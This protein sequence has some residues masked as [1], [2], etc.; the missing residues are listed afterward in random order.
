MQTPGSLYSTAPC[1][2]NSSPIRV[3]PAPGPPQMRAVRPFGK[4]PCVIWSRP[5]IP[6]GTFFKVSEEAAEAPRSEIRVTVPRVR[7]LFLSVVVDAIQVHSHAE[8]WRAKYSNVS[9]N[10]S[11]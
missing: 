8:I 7:V 10:D 6:V 1:T 9:K 3:L 5:R 4:P 2:R 11:K